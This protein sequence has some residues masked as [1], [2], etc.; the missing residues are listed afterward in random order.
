MLNN[1]IQFIRQHLRTT[2]P[3]QPYFVATEEN[4]P[5][6]YYYVERHNSQFRQ[7]CGQGLAGARD[8]QT[9]CDKLN[10]K[11]QQDQSRIATNREAMHKAVDSNRAAWERW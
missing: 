11:Y 7:Y 2:D 8:A 10:Y 1:I 4:G 9:L 6:I 5:A 3:L